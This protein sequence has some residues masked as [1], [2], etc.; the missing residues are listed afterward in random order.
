MEKS[1]LTYTDVYIKKKVNIYKNDMHVQ[2]SNDCSYYSMTF[3]MISASLKHMF[4]K[5]YL[6]TCKT[7][8]FFSIIKSI[9]VKN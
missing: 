3:I 1:I 8:F 4:T 9:C 7:M 6:G 5:N 2:A